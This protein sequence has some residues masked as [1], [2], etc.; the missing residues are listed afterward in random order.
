M[1]YISATEGRQLT[2]SKEHVR[3]LQMHGGRPLISFCYQLQLLVSSW[4]ALYLRTQ[5]ESLALMTRVGSLRRPCIKLR[6]LHMRFRTRLLNPGLRTPD[7]RSPHGNGLLADKADLSAPFP[8]GLQLARGTF[9]SSPSVWLESP[10]VN[11]C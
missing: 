6:N 5:R 10:E 2:A 9:P 4:D 8:L 7:S 11:V 1:S 3:K